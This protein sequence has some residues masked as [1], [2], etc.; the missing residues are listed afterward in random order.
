MFAS[1]NF[2]CSARDCLAC[3]PPPS[4]YLM[5]CSSLPARFSRCSLANPL[6]FFPPRSPLPILLRK[7]TSHRHQICGRCRS[8]IGPWLARWGGGGAG[9]NLDPKPPPPPCRVCRPAT[10]R[11]HLGG[12]GWTGPTR[13]RPDWCDWSFGGHLI[14]PAVRLLDDKS[15]ATSALIT[16]GPPS[17]ADCRWR[18]IDGQLTGYWRTG[19][20]LLIDSWQAVGG[21]LTGHWRAAD[22]LL[23]DSIGQFTCLFNMYEQ[24]NK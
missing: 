9:G 21:Q 2:E 5:F 7:Q 15:V 8:D 12:G 17:S 4:P 20:G 10:T 19:V 1:T 11:G 13:R 24:R 6:S 22:G 3:T 23:T 18:D 16:D 14:D